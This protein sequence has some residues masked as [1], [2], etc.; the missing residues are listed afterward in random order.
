MSETGTHSHFDT[1]LDGYPTAPRGIPLAASQPRMMP[2]P[3]DIRLIASR[4]QLFNLSPTPTIV[5][6][7]LDG[8]LG[9]PAASVV[10]Q[11]PTPYWWFLPDAPLWIPPYTINLNHNFANPLEKARVLFQAPIDRAQPAVST[12]AS[13]ATFT[14]LDAPQLPTTLISSDS[15]TIAGV[16]AVQEERA[17]TAATTSIAAAA[18]DTQLLAANAARLSASVFNQTATGIL[19]LKYGAG[20]SATSFKVAIQ[21]GGYF[22]LPEP[23]YTGAV[24]GFWSVADGFARISEET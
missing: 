4:K 16:V 1:T 7:G 15:M 24:N 18:A 22:E 3:D 12:I 11:N 9:F 13:L 6:A 20:A 23:G 8:Q 17:D 5:A 10:I 14:F 19:Y 2:N 21:P